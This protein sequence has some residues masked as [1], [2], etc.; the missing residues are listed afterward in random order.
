MPTI[1][2]PLFF[3]LLTHNNPSTLMCAKQW[4]RA[5]LLL[6]LFELCVLPLKK[7]IFIIIPII[8]IIIPMITIIIMSSYHISIHSFVIN[9][10][11]TNCKKE[12]PSFTVLSHIS[13]VLKQSG[14]YI[15]V[16]GFLHTV[17]LHIPSVLYSSRTIH[18][19]SGFHSTSVS[20][21]ACDPSASFIGWKKKL[22][23]LFDLSRSGKG[24]I[25]WSF[26]FITLLLRLTA[27][28]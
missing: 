1:F 26:T 18:K 3:H 27:K 13:C 9:Q 24:Q 23:I 8:T 2:L 14:T 20:H 22:V 7:I 6:R 28:I 21:A 10:S 12:E 19:N 11:E 25:L 15:R 5:L 4:V 17:E 16:D